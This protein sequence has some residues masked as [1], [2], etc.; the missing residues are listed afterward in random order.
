MDFTLDKKLAIVEVDD[1]TIDL[2]KNLLVKEPMQR[3]GGG[4]GN[5]D[6]MHLRIHPFF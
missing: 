1:N 3:L 6:S 2:I 5:K 4:V